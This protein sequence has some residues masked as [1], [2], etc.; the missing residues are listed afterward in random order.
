MTYKIDILVIRILYAP[1]KKLLFYL[2]NLAA[3]VA[4]VFVVAFQAKTKTYIRAHKGRERRFAPSA[5]RIL[6][7]WSDNDEALALSR[8]VSCE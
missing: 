5:L 6:R 7:I 2:N 1:D 8:R 3:A 4:N